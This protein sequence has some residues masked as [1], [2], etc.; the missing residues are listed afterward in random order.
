MSVV[1]SLRKQMLPTV[2]TMF[3]AVPGRGRRSPDTYLALASQFI[4]KL[5]NPLVVFVNDPDLVQK[6]G[7]IQPKAHVHVVPFADTYYYRHMDALETLQRDFR[8]SNGNVDHETPAYVVLNN[9]KHFFVEETCRLYPDV[10]HLVWLDFGVNHVARMPADSLYIPRDLFDK[11]KIRQMCISPYVEYG[12]PKD[13]FR[14]IWHHTAGGLF[15]GSRANMLEYAGLFRAKTEQIYAEN[16]WQVD[17]AVMTMVQRENPAL[18]DFYYGDYEGIVANLVDPV[19]KYNIDLVFYGIQK[20]F[21]HNNPGAAFHAL[22]WC[23][24]LFVPDNSETP[25]EGV[26][27]GLLCRWMAGH[28][29]ADFYD[30]NRQLSN[31]V[32]DAM[33]M[34]KSHD[35]VKQCLSN[36]EANLRYYDVS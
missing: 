24:R 3:Y 11:N 33:E 35:A 14:H 31:A 12:A 20:A 2:V 10:E 7:D 15:G 36:N 13:T 23:D 30:N 22:A 25:I 17:E 9:N 19:P 27:L 5:E 8:L 1:L 28:I 4:L 32:L 29:V 6:I 26:N 21:D 18:F 16:W 34:Y